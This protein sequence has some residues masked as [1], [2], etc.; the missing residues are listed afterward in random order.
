MGV[1]KAGAYHELFNS[2]A[3]YFGGSNV[4]NGPGSLMAEEQPWMN[5]PYSLTVTLPPLAGI[6][7]KAGELPTGGR[8]E[9]PIAA[10]GKSSA[11]EP[12]PASK[13]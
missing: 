11:V 9:N 4:V 8:G 1:P 13:P 10:I 2:D 12:K 7:L 3:D 5:K 6:I